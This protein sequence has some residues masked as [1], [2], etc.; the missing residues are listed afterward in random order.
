M[1]SL[2]GEGNFCKYANFRKSVCTC[3]LFRCTK[4]RAAIESRQPPAQLPYT[5]R[6]TCVARTGRACHPY[7]LRAWPVRC[8]AISPEV[9][10]TSS[11]ARSTTNEAAMARHFQCNVSSVQKTTTFGKIVR[12]SC[13]EQNKTLYLQQKQSCNNYNLC[14]P[15]PT[16]PSRALKR[17]A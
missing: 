4:H 11:R 5:V 10:A 1:F 17:T 3:D 14:R 12:K 6:A 8:A 15:K 7:A 9:R 2:Q 16:K 13:T